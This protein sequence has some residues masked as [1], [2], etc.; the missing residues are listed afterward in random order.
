MAPG[1][2]GRLGDRLDNAGL[3]V[4]RHQ[5]YHHRLGRPGECRLER[6]QIDPPI[7][8]DRN[9]LGFRRGKHRR[10]LDGGDQDPAPHRGKPG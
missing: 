10:V 1:E 9:L 5:R 3:V 4:G 6:R 7:G 2:R 8:Q